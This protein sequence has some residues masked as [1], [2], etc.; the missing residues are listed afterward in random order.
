[1]QVN[2]LFVVPLSCTP[3]QQMRPAQL[4]NPVDSTDALVTS[5]DLTMQCKTMPFVLL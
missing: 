5:W 4:E 1:M 2:Q 3:A